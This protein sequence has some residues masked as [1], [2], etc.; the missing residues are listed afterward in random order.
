MI[1]LRDITRRFGERTVIENLNFTFPDKGAFALMGPSGCGKTTLLR[2]L[3]KLDRP[4][5]GSV[6][7]SHRKI[8]MAFQEPRLLPWLNCEDNLKLVLSKDNSS[9]EN[10]QKW[11]RLFELSDTAKQYPSTLSG[12]MKQRLSLARALAF[13]GDLLLLDE[14]FSALDQALKM[15]IAPHIREACRHALTVFVT[16]DPSDADLLGATV[17]HCQGSPLNTLSET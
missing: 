14:P 7:H 16:H 11:L 9:S 15:R 17:L 6:I 2:L 13:G 8:S 12:G 3:A 1:E 4:E 5:I 10:T